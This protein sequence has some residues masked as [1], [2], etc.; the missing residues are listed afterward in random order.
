[1]TLFFIILVGLAAGV[2]VGLQGPFASLISQK[3]GMLESVFIVHLGGMVVALIPLL[4]LGG[5]HLRNWRSLPWY[6]LTAGAF[7]LIVLSAI[8]YMIPRIGIASAFLLLILGQ[9]V[10]GII[11]DHFGLFGT[12]VRTFDW[13]K[14]TGFAI[15]FLGVWL[16]V[17]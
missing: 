10:V 11:L 3:L 2:A 5:G 12:T 9:V 8:S 16:V 6:T 15:A 4:F 13:V 14:L 1:M 17:R 7:G